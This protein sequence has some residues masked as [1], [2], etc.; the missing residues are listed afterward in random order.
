MIGRK[1]KKRRVD[2]RTIT[3]P[4][5]GDPFYA[6]PDDALIALIHAE[7]GE[8]PTSRTSAAVADLDVHHG[9]ALERARASLRE[10]PS[11]HHLLVTTMLEDRPHLLVYRNE[12]GRLVIFDDY[13]KLAVAQELGLR[14][15]RVLI[16]GE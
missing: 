10:E 3:P 8:I 7:A 12:A 16:Y 14:E 13:A 2:S 9:P 5:A 4:K 11:L 15:V 1:P 6:P